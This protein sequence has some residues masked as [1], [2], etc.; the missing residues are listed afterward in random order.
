MRYCVLSIVFIC[1]FFKVGLSQL[2]VNTT[3][4]PAQLAQTL[5]GTGVTVS[6]VVYKGVRLASKGYQIAAFTA[7]T[8]TKT[9]LG[10]N[11]G[12]IMS[13]GDAAALPLALG[14]DPKDQA[15]LSGSYSSS[16]VGETRKGNATGT[17]L[18]DGNFL[19]SNGSWYNASILEFDFVPLCDNFSFRYVF[20]SEEY[21]DGFSNYQC[22]DFNDK[23]AFL[24]SGPGISGT[25]YSNA[26]VNLAKLANGSDVGINSVNSGTSGGTNSYCQNA[27]PA[28][29]LNTPVAEF[30]GV[31][32][33]IQL[34]GN[35]KILTAKRTGLTP[36]A[37]YH[38]KFI[39]MD[40]QDSGYDSA[41]FLEAGSFT[42]PGVT[43]TGQVFQNGTLSPN[44]LVITEGCATGKVTVQISS[45]STTN[46]TINYN[47]TGS[48]ATSGTDYT[49]LSG[50]LTIPAGQT[51]GTIDLT[52][53]ND[54]VPESPE[55]VVIS[56]SSCGGSSSNITFTIVDPLQIT[57]GT[58]SSSGVTFNWNN[59][60]ATTYDYSYSV[61]NGAA[62]TGSTANTTLP[63]NSLSPGSSVKITITPKFP[64]G[65]GC[66]VEQTCSTIGCGSCAQPTCGIS[67]PH[68]NPAEANTKNCDSPG[69]VTVNPAVT[70][71][72]Y[73]SYHTL[74]ADASGK[75]GVIVNTNTSTGG[76]CAITKSAVLY[77]ASP[78]TGAGVAATTT[79]ANPT[80]T[81]YN[82]EWSGLTPNGNYIL[83]I[84]YTI[85]SGCS[86]NNHCVSFYH[87]S[88]PT[89]T[90]SD[91]CKTD[92]ALCYDQ[93]TYNATKQYSVDPSTTLTRCYTVNSGS[94]GF[95]GLAQ[96]TSSNNVTRSAQLF[97]NTC[98]AS[99]AINP[100][101]TSVNTGVGGFNPEWENLTIDKNYTMCITVQNTGSSVAQLIP[102]TYWSKICCPAD[103]GTVTVFINGQVVNNAT[104]E[105]NVCWGDTLVFATNSD[106]TLQTASSADPNGLGYVIYDAA[107]SNPDPGADPG[108]IGFDYNPI[109]GDVNNDLGF[110]VGTY[111]IRAITMDDICKDGTC[112]TD[113][114]YDVNSDGCYDMGTVMKFTFHPEVIAVAGLDDTLC[115][116]ESITLTATGG[117]NYTWN[118]GV[119]QGTAFQPNTTKDYIVTA[120]ST[121]GCTDTDTLTIVV[122]ESP[123]VNAGLDKNICL[124]D[125]IVLSASGAQN[126]SWNLG[127][128][129]GD[130]LTPTASTTYIVTGTNGS[131]TD[132]DTVVITVNQAPQIDFTA[133]VNEGCAPLEVHFT[134]NSSP[135]DQC[136]WNMGNGIQFGSCGNTSFTF[137]APGCYTISLTGKVGGCQTK[138]TKDSLV[139]VEAVPTAGFYP[140]P[141]L[142]SEI[143]PLVKFTNGSIGASTYQWNFG[144]GT[145]GNGTH[146]TH[147]YSNATLG[148]HVIRLI[149]I[150]DFGC[151][152]TTY[153][154]VIMQ[155]DLLYYVP[156]C[157]TPDG[158][159]FNQEFKPV[160]T[161]GYD[162]SGF[163]MLIFDRWGS[164]IFQS[165]EV[166][167]GWDGRINGKQI[168][169]E[170]AYAWK[171]EFKDKNTDERYEITG[172]VSIMR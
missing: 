52:V 138:L 19:C 97:L 136:I 42:S 75:L 36:G 67:G 61:N 22:T 37:T 122:Y 129:N 77:A 33:G 69:N 163:K 41:V 134:N 151:R 59:I 10:F 30:L 127:V 34:N 158:D 3:T 161:S 65:S 95:I 87:T 169:Q 73:D 135:S 165:D 32:D 124:G 53:A 31:I 58:S 12:V 39:I 131:C 9:Q 4:L 54:G 29:V 119:I 51:S 50:T 108:M 160:F 63:V 14:Q 13:T 1:S 57:C 123:T 16:D 115:S 110:P 132:K 96:Q 149:A 25:G 68:A 152:D 78:C 17:N 155:E 168:A 21:D 80:I 23:F 15:T 156:N 83:K 40:L 141:T 153:M 6:N 128:T 157:F 82:P 79:T 102:T 38:I 144:D 140:E 55:T 70:N 167:V 113:R 66:P 18:T 89:C 5:A 114:G 126:L 28:W 107:P 11:G 104:N 142:I 111:W 24:I 150:S 2:T 85:P 84:T 47:T 118:N 8:T 130:T 159:N 93:V 88:V 100:T 86:M 43:S 44:N 99:A 170:G 103:A 166:T 35:T 71:T 116:G 148:E 101:N 117:D 81:G 26:A 72:T 146:P 162:P 45:A 164:L 147:N 49:A 137:D 90:C 27:N 64:N 48:T 125:T 133:D 172:H 56:A 20:G 76:T 120:S 94:S 7:A 98:D 109:T 74:K 143:H 139:C 145:N 92:S 46:Q 171:I 60:G 62:I 105:Y 106:F 91:P 121:T 112:N 154:S